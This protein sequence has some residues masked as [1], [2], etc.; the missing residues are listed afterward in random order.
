VVAATGLG[1]QI[2]SRLDSRQDGTKGGGKDTR[3]VPVVTA[4]IESAAIALERSFSGTLEAHAELV[5]APKIGGIV[6]RLSVDLGDSVARG[7]MVAKLDNAEF[8]QAVAQAEADL[9]VARANLERATA[10]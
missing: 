8:V 5:A 9:K 6:K 4:P 3:P 10:F 2:H 7:Q 1:W